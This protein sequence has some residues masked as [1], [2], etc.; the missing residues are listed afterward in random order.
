LVTRT[1]LSQEPHILSLFGRPGAS[2][3]HV[4]FAP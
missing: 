3:H 1:T 4:N 2:Q